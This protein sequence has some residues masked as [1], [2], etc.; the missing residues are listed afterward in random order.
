MTD[1]N[2]SRDHVSQPAGRL[3]LEMENRTQVP[4]DC[5]SRACLPGARRRQRRRRPRTAWLGLFEACSREPFTRAHDA[6]R[7]CVLILLRRILIAPYGGKKIPRLQLPA[8]E[9]KWKE[10]WARGRETAEAINS[11]KFD[12]KAHDPSYEFG[13]RRRTDPEQQLRRLH[14]RQ[15]DGARPVRRAAGGGDDANLFRLGS[16]PARSD[17]QALCGAARLSRQGRP[18]AAFQYNYRLVYII[19]L[20]IVRSSLRVRMMLTHLKRRFLR[21]QSVRCSSCSGSLPRW[22]AVSDCNAF[23]GSVRSNE[24]LRRTARQA[25]RS[26]D[27]RS[28]RL[29]QQSEDCGLSREIRRR[30]GR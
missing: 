19:C 12:Y 11:Q 20:G 30:R 2:P 28:K 5:P 4:A 27:C 22:P 15:G 14:A 9:R 21:R 7:G 10:L 13:T 24:C 3:D 26:T 18:L 17:V 8:P 29:D 25:M 16:R 23:E 6:R 1:R